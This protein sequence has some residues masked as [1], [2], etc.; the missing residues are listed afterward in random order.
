MS[1][2]AVVSER[3]ESAREALAWGTSTLSKEIE[4]PS[5][6]AEILLG[7]V[8][9]CSR[10]DLYAY[11]NRALAQAQARIFESLVERRRAWE[12][13]QYLTGKQWFRG[14]ELKVGPGVLVPRPETEVLVERA[15]EL[16]ARIE[17]PLVADIGT[18]S[19]AIALSIAAERPDAEVWA[20]DSS[21]EALKWARLNLEALGMNDGVRVL[22]SDLFEGF[23]DSLKARF[24]L[25]VTNP[26]YLSNAELAAAQSDVRE[27]EPTTATLSGPTGLE[28]SARVI[29]EAVQ[30]LGLGWLVLEIAPDRAREVGLCLERHYANVEIKRDLA[31]R[32]RVAAARRRT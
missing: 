4:N 3:F 9:G 13:L 30:W 14:F 27:H 5:R 29:D 12:P 18:G 11:S 15:L 6:E 1:E 24:D 8:L 16:I 2:R 26:P 31:W 10:T 21:V 25:I 19:G 20:S 28:F 17:R 22:E 7:H 23:P 32:L